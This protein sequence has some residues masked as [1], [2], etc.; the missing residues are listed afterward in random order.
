MKTTVESAHL[1]L[2]Q[3]ARLRTTSCTR[4]DIS[5]RPLV[6]NCTPVCSEAFLPWATVHT[7]GGVHGRMVKYTYQNPKTHQTPTPI[8]AQLRQKRH[9]HTRPCPYEVS[10]SP[11][12]QRRRSKPVG[13]H[14][15]I[16]SSPFCVKVPV[17]SLRRYSM[18]PSSSGNVLVRTI[19]LGIS[20]SV[21]I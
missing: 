4:E 19:V 2:W 18:R 13:G 16:A 11:F 10:S 15:K 14:A 9:T 21:M 1:T 5:R 3:S 7:S 12:L 20:L 6:A 8:D 17:L